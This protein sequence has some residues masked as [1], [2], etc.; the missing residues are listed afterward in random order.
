MRSLISQEPLGSC[1]RPLR[2]A[3]GAVK[4]DAAAVQGLPSAGW[5]WVVAQLPTPSPRAGVS[6]VKGAKTRSF[7][8]GVSTHLL[9]ELGQVIP[10]FCASD[11]SL[12]KWGV[13][14]L[15]VLRTL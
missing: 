8:A 9:C 5:S 11:S 14:W 7:R 12:I 1:S 4:A 3:G 6:L 13:G 2:L 15:N 10:L